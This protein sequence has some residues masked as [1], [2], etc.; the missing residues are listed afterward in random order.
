LSKKSRKLNCG[1]GSPVSEKPLVEISV[2]I[3]QNIQLTY[4]VKNLL[5]NQ[6]T[7]NF[8]RRSLLQRE[9]SLIVDALT[10]MAIMLKEQDAIFSLPYYRR[11][12]VPW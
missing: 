7:V 9:I 8:S 12:L 1:R 3:Q 2:T 11:K 4:Q 10:N 5:T 6:A